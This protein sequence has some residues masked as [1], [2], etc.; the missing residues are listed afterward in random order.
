MRFQGFVLD[1]IYGIWRREAVEKMLNKQLLGLVGA[2]STTKHGE[3]TTRVNKRRGFLS[4]T[5]SGN[6][7]LIPIK[8]VF[9]FRESDMQAVKQRKRR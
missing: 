9:N 4:R 2:L 3:L 7:K 1:R 6:V 8:T 5:S